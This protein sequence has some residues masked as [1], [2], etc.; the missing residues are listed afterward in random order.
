[1]AKDYFIIEYEGHILAP[2]DVMEVAYFPECQRFFYTDFMRPL[3]GRKMEFGGGPQVEGDAIDRAIAEMDAAGVDIAFVIP[4]RFMYASADAK[5]LQSNGW[6]LKVCER[7]PDRLFPAP[8]FHPT[9]RGIENAIWE[10][11]YFAKEK[12]CKFFKFYPPDETMPMNDKRLWPFYAKAEELGLVMGVHTGL[13]YVYGGVSEY[14]HPLQLEEV[15]R[16]FYDLK[17]VAFH[18]G[19]PWH[20]ELNALANTYPNLYV[21]MSYL[22]RAIKYRPRWFAELL[23]EAILWATVD[24]IVW[25]CDGITELKEPVEAFKE[26][27]FPE[28]MQKGYGYPSLTE[29]DKAKIFGLNFARL[30]GIEPKKRV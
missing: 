5:P 11:E 13:A 16:K 28:D 24:K 25:G 29:E 9:K 14:C 21:G 8:N 4:E 26:F 3:T 22:N 17:I 1:M 2:E 15:C 30:V 23:G 10:M 27:Q 6:L 19:W 18:F 7:Y 20:H 12:G